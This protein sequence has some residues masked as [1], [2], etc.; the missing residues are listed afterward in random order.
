MQIF[1][2]PPPVCLG[3]SWYG[4]LTT[5]QQAPKPGL[6]EGHRGHRRHAQDMGGGWGLACPP[7]ASPVN[8]WETLGVGFF[9]LVL[10]NQCD[11]FL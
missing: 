5:P 4:V 8:L 10:T 6:W 3:A 11:F 2:S 1:A 7:T 9:L